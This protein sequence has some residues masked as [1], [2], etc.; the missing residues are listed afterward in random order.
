M[1]VPINMLLAFV[2]ALALSSKALKH[3]RT[4]FRLAV[5][6][7]VITSDLVVSIVW[8]WMY[9][10]E[11]G[12]VN[13]V[14][15]SLGLQ[16][17]G[18]LA[19]PQ[20][21]LLA[22]MFVALWKNVGLYTVIFMTNIQLIDPVLYESADIDGANYPQKVW[23]ITIPELR[24]AILL[25]SIYAVIQFLKVFTLAR[26]MTGG[27]PNFSSNFTAFYAYE[28]FSK[29]NNFGEATAMGTILFLIVIIVFMLTYWLNRRGTQ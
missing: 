19:S 12:A 23:H 22:L 9:N 29:V 3:G 5:F 24:P 11:Y 14:L 27:G 16:P 21:V 26:V 1:S 25:N 6:L 13:T 10:T 18:G 17:F 20:T 15:Q 4:L 8:R 2:F 7:P 28:R